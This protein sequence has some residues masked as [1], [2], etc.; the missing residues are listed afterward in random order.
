MKILIK[1][2][3]VIDPAN[4]ID[5]V[6]DILIEN[7]VIAQIGNL[8]SHVDA[9]HTIDARDRWVIP[10]LIDLCCRPQL[11][12]PHGS[13]LAIEAKAAL[14]RGFTGICIPPDGEP[15]PSHVSN[16]SAMSTIYRIGALTADGTDN[17]INDL[18]ALAQ[19]GCVAFTT[20][21]KPIT[22]LSLLRHCYEY[23][24]S[25]NLMVIIQPQEPTLSHRGVAHEGMMATRLG[26]PG[27][28]ESAETCAVATHLR[29]IE[30]TGVRAH[31][32][33][34]S[35]Q[36]AVEQIEKF[37]AFLPIT[38]DVSMH[39]LYLTEQDLNGFDA[40][41]HLYPPLRSMRDR[42]AL[43][44]GVASGVIDAICSDHRPLHAIANLRRLP[45]QSLACRASM[46]FYRSALRW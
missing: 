9:V 42:D 39:H 19:T 26:L 30:Q 27:I 25:F 46:S 38:A 33:C 3:H 20:A 15:L 37:K 23:A 8:P 1:N 5:K 12:H 2:G 17:T 41:C 40:N 35:T 36:G 28:P 7:N 44:T 10:G 16:E 14:Q 45:T 31:F 11:P 4:H 32:T 29:L 34:L 21:Q 6:T 43:L 18:T 24:A 22:N 13:Q